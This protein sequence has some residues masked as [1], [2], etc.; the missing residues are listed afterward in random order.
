MIIEVVVI[1]EIADLV[2][3]DSNPRYQI[4]TKENTQETGCFFYRIEFKNPN[5]SERFFKT[6]SR[7][8]LV[9]FGEIVTISV[10]SEI[11]PDLSFEIALK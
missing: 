3:I 5:A 6:K 7:A 11:F 1:E 10:L 4:E 8:D 2:E 9:A